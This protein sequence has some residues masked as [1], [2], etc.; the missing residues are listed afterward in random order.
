[1]FHSSNSIEWIVNCSTMKNVKIITYF[2]RKNAFLIKCQPCNNY[3]MVFD[4]KSN[5]PCILSA[6]LQVATPPDSRDNPDMCLYVCGVGHK[7]GPLLSARRNSWMCGASDM[8]LCSNSRCG[9]SSSS[10]KPKHRRCTQK[11]SN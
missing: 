10:L 9:G 1:V 7:R 2:C 4:H 8:R 5:L 6:F 3:S 11:L